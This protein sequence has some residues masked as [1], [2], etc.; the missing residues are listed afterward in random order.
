MD[1][2]DLVW[3]NTL[4][5]YIE[6]RL[7]FASSEKIDLSYIDPVVTGRNVFSATNEV[8]CGVEDYIR[9]K[10]CAVADAVLDVVKG[11]NSGH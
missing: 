4:I 10:L 6:A 9:T 1:L 11:I 7:F 5:Y 3:A 2:I 8:I